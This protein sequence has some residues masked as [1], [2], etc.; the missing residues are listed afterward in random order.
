L[1]L[2]YVINYNNQD[3]AQNYP[4]FETGGEQGLQVLFDYMLDPLDPL[5]PDRSYLAFTGTTFFLSS[6]LF[7]CLKI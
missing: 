7:C 2:D 4:L 5:N 3:I 1:R 6:A